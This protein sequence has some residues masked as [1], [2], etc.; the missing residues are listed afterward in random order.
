MLDRPAGLGSGP[1]KRRSPS[2]RWLLGLV[3]ATLAALFGIHQ[4]YPGAP[5]HGGRR[6]AARDRAPA[7]KAGQTV[8]AQVLRLADGDSLTVAIGE[9]ESGVRLFGVDC[10]ES[11][12]ARGAEAHAF[13]AGLLAPGTAITVRVM[14]E[15]RYGRLVGEVFLPDGRSLNVLLVQSGW[16][17][18]YQ[19]YAPRRRDLAMAEQKARERRRGVWQDPAPTPPWEWRQGHS[20]Y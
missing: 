8:N 2:R 5:T 16:A 1:V 12:Q 19:S 3:A 6:A 13:T 9:A 15:D 20:R 11:A 14:D 18:W 17:W 10:P 4:Y 7:A